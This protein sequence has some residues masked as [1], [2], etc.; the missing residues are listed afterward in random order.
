MNEG[1]TPKN[2][3]RRQARQ[4]A[5]GTSKD[6]INPKLDKQLNLMNHENELGVPMVRIFFRI[7]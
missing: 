6:R 5:E 1:E 7:N 2:S 3:R 4:P